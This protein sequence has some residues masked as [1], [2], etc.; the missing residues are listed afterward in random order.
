MAL[1]YGAHAVRIINPMVNGYALDWCREYARDCGE[2]AASE[3]CRS[4]GYPGGYRKVSCPAYMLYSTSSNPHRHAVQSAHALHVLKQLPMIMKTTKH[5]DHWTYIPPNL[6]LKSQVGPRV[7]VRPSAWREAG[8]ASSPMEQSAT[9][10]TMCATPSPGL[11]GEKEQGCIVQE[12]DIPIMYAAPSQCFPS[13][14]VGCVQ[15]CPCQSRTP[16]KHP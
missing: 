11:T 8:R 3:F 16:V 5:T 10:A 15:F 2:P 4:K 7:S 6:F 9:P 13:Q 14:R 12:L 1:C